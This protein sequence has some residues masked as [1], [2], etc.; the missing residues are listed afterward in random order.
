MKQPF[1]SVVSPV[2]NEAAYIEGMLGSLFANDLPADR[3]EVLVV[4]GMSDD[5][6]REAVRRLMREHPNLRL[7][8]NPDKTVPYAMNAGI[9]AARG[10]VIVR[11]DGHAEV[12]PSFLRSLLEELEA[13]PEAACVGGTIEN[14]HENRVAEAVALAMASPFG[15]GDARYRL[16]DREGY[17]DTLLFGAYRAEVFDEIGLFDEVLTRNQDDELNYRLTSAGHRIWLSTRISSRYY[18][19]AS[20]RKLWRQY[21]QYGYWKVYV[22][23]KHRTVTSLRQLAPIALVAFLLLGGL[24]AVFAPGLRPLY[25]LGLG[26]YLL[27]GIGAAWLKARR[28]GPTLRVFAAFATMH[29]AYGLGYLEGLVDFFLL[30]RTPSARNAQLSR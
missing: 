30:Q 8:D 22:N 24:G 20:Y 18:V 7:L 16:A 9:R 4:D 11:V 10:D 21:F 13:H 1:V 6:T 12:A 5:G 19:R 15:V 2:Y 3:Y 28:P 29:L 27:A 23:R 26:V 25:G 14:V 17:V